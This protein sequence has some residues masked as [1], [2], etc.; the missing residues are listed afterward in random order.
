MKLNESCKIIG[1][2]KQIMSKQHMK[3]NESCKKKKKIT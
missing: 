3:I 2:N 1:E